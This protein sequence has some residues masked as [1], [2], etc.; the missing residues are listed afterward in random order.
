MQIKSNKL[1]CFGLVLLT[2]V[3]M[4]IGSAD[5]L[6]V[7][8][9]SHFGGNA[10][11]IEVVGDYAYL[12]QGQDLVIMDITDDDKSIEKGRITT[13]SVVRSVAVASNYAYVA[14]DN[15]LVIIDVS[16]PS[17][18]NILNTFAINGSPQEV[19]VSDN[20]AYVVTRVYSGDE[21][22][23]TLEIVD[24]TNSASPTV[25]G[26]YDTYGY[27]S[28]VDVEGNYAYMSDV[29]EGLI[30]LN[31]TDPSSPKVEGTISGSISD[32]VTS[33]NYT[34]TINGSLNIDNIA[35]PSSPTFV[36]EYF[37]DYGTIEN[38][39]ISGNYAYL[40]TTVYLADEYHDMLE[41]VDIS[42]TTAP[43][44][45]G[46]YFG[47]DKESMNSITVS[48][49]YAYIADDYGGFMKIDVSNPNSPQLANKYD[50][51]GSV[52]DVAVSGNY[53]YLAESGNGLVIADISDQSSP[54][55][56]GSYDI[57]DDA[58]KV[59]VLGDYAYLDTHW[60]SNI[61][62]L[63]IVDVSNP[64]SPAMNGV[65]SF[66]PDSYSTAVADNY[67]Y[68]ANYDVVDIVN[69]D[70][71]NP[72]SPN[73]VGSI[74]VSAKDIAASGDYAYIYAEG[75]GF[76]V[77]NATNPSSPKIEGSY[78]VD[79]NIA[80]SGNY[81]YVANGANG[82]VILDVSNPSSP[83]LAGG[84]DGI[85]ASDVVISGDYAYV[86]T[87][88]GLVILDITDSASPTLA[89]TYSIVGNSV[90]VAV[91]YIYVANGEKGLTILHM[92]ESDKT[93]SSTSITNLKET[94]VSTN[95]INW[96]WTNPTSTD[97]S[98]VIVNIDGNFVGN[99]SKDYYNFTGLS[100]GTVH[101]ISIKTVF[102]SGGS[103]NTWVSDSA[104]TLLPTD[105]I[106]PESVTDLE[107]ESVG[108][109]WINWTWTKPASADFSHV[110]VY[111]DNEF[112]GNSSDTHYNLT[113]LAEGTTHTISTRTVD[114]SGNINS[115][116][117]NDSA[118][119]LAS[120]GTTSTVP[121]TISGLIG[122][123]ISSSAITLTW[124]NSLDI[125]TVAIYRNNVIVGN[126]SGSTSYT[127]S[128]LASSTAYNYTL[129]PYN[130]DGVAGEA[131]SVILNTGSSSSSNSG[132]SSGGSSSSKSSSSSSSGGSGGSAS[133][134][135]FSNLAVKDAE[136]KYLAINANIT[137]EFS[138]E[139]NPIQSISFYSLKN[140]GDVT[141]TVET[142]NNRSKTVN[143]TPEGL[144]YKYVNI[145]VGK[146]GF[147]TADNIKDATIKFKVE[148]SWIE[149]MGV[150]AENV[151][152]Q[153]YDG[154]GWQILPTTLES[155]TT[156]Y[157]VFEA[158]TPGFSQ[159]SITAEREIAPS[160]TDEAGTTPA[161]TD[162]AAET[163][164]E[165]TPGFGSYMTILMIGIVAVG[166][167]NL[168]R[169]QN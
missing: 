135:D 51:A 41:I 104:Q 25:V 21:Y 99:T 42:N 78:D 132:S 59:E 15:G 169:K 121:P 147:A 110:I 119:T 129:I 130:K 133:T 50:N 14:N 80:I 72:S 33:G 95:W 54:T 79:G 75:D 38:V 64:S 166:Y 35:D 156:S 140:S 84:Y 20:Y 16:N 3:T 87:D 68:I 106:A 90:A 12:G 115:N 56:T 19:V 29:S 2:I 113:G 36:S 125:T 120:E 139:G 164:P 114:M 102:T 117:V 60:F 65:W 32:V 30:I 96:T 143:A 37:S 43:V 26:S 118:K 160:I 100:E 40:L 137:Y 94:G 161:Q 69:V 124:T 111:L 74:S 18:L 77:L 86:T 145:W 105:T 101:T 46:T 67:A 85:S 47:D 34:Y 108:S 71:S 142:L 148:N 61:N 123:N 66:D 49:N 107:E 153:R 150:S 52:F 159:F 70:M 131:V 89:G 167:A 154:T 57:S 168:K 97:F 62:A 6:N 136:S 165:E 112:A 82:I 17:S 163:Q 76:V 4:G 63:H 93:A 23:N 98:H 11:D 7:E 22:Y 109:S 44:Y 5:P 48:G 88:S 91:D 162:A 10:Y 138:K 92:E 53:A 146:A 9:V 152:L 8:Y 128:N 141:A 122:K 81:A 158:Q 151:K 73:V 58:Y 155:N 55:F 157:A 134:E 127:D 13:S 39:A 1:F 149:E 103:N 24:V 31:I 27:R 126:V 83:K 28:I 116:W 45:M 144:L